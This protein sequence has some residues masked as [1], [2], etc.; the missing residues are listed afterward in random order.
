MTDE[1][2]V[3]FKKEKLAEL[4]P[5][6]RDAAVAML[7]EKLV[8]VLPELRERIAENPATWLFG[9]ENMEC[10]ICYGSGEIVS[11]RDTVPVPLL[12]N[13]SLT[14]GEWSAAV[15]RL[16]EDPDNCNPPETCYLC[17]G[18]GVTHE[19]PLHHGWGT[20]IRNLLRSE[21]FTEEHMDVDNLDDYYAQLVELAANE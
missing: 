18:S 14:L 5:E 11:L 15:D 19:P 10:Y 4:D 20:G 1:E 9:R 7:R 17:K 6:K 3:E 16:R 2:W 13:G 21:G 12:S 8:H